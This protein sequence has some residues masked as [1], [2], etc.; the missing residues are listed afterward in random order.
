MSKAHAKCSPSAAERWLHCTAA[1]NYETQFPDE[2]ASVYASE[3]TLAHEFAELF[4]RRI[5]SKVTT[6]TFNSRLKKL[7]AKEQYSPEMERTAQF[8]AEY[9]FRKA[10]EFAAVPHLALEVGVDIGTYVPQG[11]GRCDCVLI[12]GDALHITDYKHGAGVAVSAEGNPQMRLY[13]LGALE[14]YRIAYPTISRV[15]MAIVQP[16]ITEDIS[17][18]SMTAAELLQWGAEIQP[19]AKEA[20][21]GPGTFAPGEWCR[22][23]KGRAVCRA[24][25]DHYLALEQKLTT[26]LSDEEVG[27]AL[28]RGAGLSAWLSDLQGYALKTILDGG[29][30]AGWK[31]VE[32]RSVRRFNDLD[33]ALKV[34][35]AEGYDDALLFDRKPKSLTEL[36]KLMGKKV[37]AEKCAAFIEKPPGKPTLAEASDKRP[38]YNSM[39]ADAAGLLP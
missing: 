36:E 9:L 29:E 16:R 30:I 22:W 8:Y 20:Y 37:F 7:Q 17:E 28:K 39:A 24:R 14:R 15:S 6:R 10:S 1:P 38:A 23:C 3:G 19:L 5:F 11:F 35:E 12:G 4:A 31:V 2:P 34:F 26:A 13:A 32:G 18:D 25:A 33:G 27:D 21:E